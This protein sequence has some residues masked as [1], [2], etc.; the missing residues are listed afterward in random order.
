MYVTFFYLNPN[1]SYYKLFMYIMIKNN[2]F[3]NKEND[4][5]EFR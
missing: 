5:I 1:N 2:E 4:L 3:K